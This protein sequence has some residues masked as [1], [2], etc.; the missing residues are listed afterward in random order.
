MLTVFGSGARAHPAARDLDIG[1]L[2]ERG[3]QP[4]LLALIRD[5]AA[6]TEAD[7]DVVLLDQ[8]GR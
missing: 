4:D 3:T 7:I 6:L 5:L 8:G 1:V 2:P